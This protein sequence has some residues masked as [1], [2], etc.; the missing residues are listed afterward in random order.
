MRR[1]REQTIE[2]S[3]RGFLAAG[4]AALA[5]SRASFGAVRSQ[6][7]AKYTR[8]NLNSPEAIPMLASY[9]K[10]VTV[11]L[12]LP[13]TDARNWYRNAFIHLL[14]CPHG[15]WWF[16]PWH[17]GYIGWFEQTCRELSGDP[18][19][20]F[21][22]WDWTAEQ[23]HGT[24][25]IPASFSQDNALNPSNDLFIKS[26]DTFKAAFESPT[27]EFYKGLNMDQ[28]DALAVRY[29]GQPD[30]QNTPEGFWKSAEPAWFGTSPRNPDFDQPTKIA[31]SP[32]TIKA[33]LRTKTF[34]VAG[35]SGF[36]SG[37]AP[38]HSNSI[39]QSQ[40]ILESQPHNLIHNATGG[41]GPEGFMTEFFSPVDPI[42]FMHHSN[43]DRL[44]DVWTRKQE[45]LRLPTL[46]E[47]GLD[48]WQSE[49]FLFYVGPDGKPIA[50]KKDDPRGQA[51]YYATIGNFDY[52]YTPGSGEDAVLKSYVPSKFSSQA[53]TSK[54]SS[55]TVGIG[56]MA[57]ASTDLPNGLDEE[58][59]AEGSD[60]ELVAEIALTLPTDRASNK[61]HVFVNP[62]A[63]S[64]SVSFDD[65]GFAGSIA[66]FGRHGHSD[67]PVTFSIPITAAV[68]ALRKAG[69]LKGGEP[70]N[71]HVVAAGS[72][73]SV[74]LVPVETPLASVTI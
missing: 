2:F 17:R 62:P 50:T 52:T 55:R 15:N 36:G 5:M 67:S 60:S 16:L 13:P 35:V 64:R 31:V 34:S 71:V 48:R 4:G 45:K 7:K 20:A 27:Q 74:E 37:E 56:K 10:A 19:F 59:Q 43:I 8:V 42:F 49:P 72:R 23:V 24:L 70:L 61:F 28:L 22:Y 14:D 39:R 53:F 3:R 54:L 41:P 47:N 33:A 63:G 57:V 12:Q 1:S 46:P 21:P 32:E 66:P 65:P 18:N 11:M 73:G 68:K 29:E 69:R 30:T 40:G 6:P 26:Y 44:W 25:G 38:Q 9:N 51:G 58:V